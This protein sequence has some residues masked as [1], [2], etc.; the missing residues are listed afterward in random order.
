[1]VQPQGVCRPHRQHTESDGQRALDAAMTSLSS[2]MTK[3]LQRNKLVPGNFLSN[4]DT[5]SVFNKPI[6]LRCNFFLKKGNLTTIK[7]EV[8]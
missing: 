5:Q 8:L 6:S 2:L 4:E 7:Y 1:M 3:P